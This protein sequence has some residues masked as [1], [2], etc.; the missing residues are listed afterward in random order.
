MFVC[1][2]VAASSELLS[3]EIPGALFLSHRTRIF[4]TALL[5]FSA[6]C[7][8]W[9]SWRADSFEYVVSGYLA[10]TLG[11]VMGW[12]FVAGLVA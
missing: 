4:V 7:L 6:Y 9:R 12:I 11:I 8:A 3:V 2:L 5:L 1:G 10:A